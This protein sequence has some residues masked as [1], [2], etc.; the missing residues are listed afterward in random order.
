M[1][2]NR[3]ALAQQLLEIALRYKLTGY[4]GDWEWD[5]SGAHQRSFHWLGWNATMAHIASVLSPHGIGLGLSINSVCE[6]ESLAINADPTCAP[7][8]AELT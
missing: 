6:S 2:E 3:E 1:F 5:S 4:T 7:A 8:G